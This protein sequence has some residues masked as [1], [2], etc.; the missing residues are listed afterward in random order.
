MQLLKSLFK[1]PAQESDITINP[2]DLKQ[3]LD[4]GGLSYIKEIEV[5]S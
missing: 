4:I 2:N 1:T 5:K 3:F